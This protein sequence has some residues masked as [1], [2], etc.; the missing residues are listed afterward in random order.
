MFLI[1]RSAVDSKIY[2]CVKLHTLAVKQQA[3]IQAEQ[4]QD[5]GNVIGILGEMLIDN[6]LGNIRPAKLGTD[7]AA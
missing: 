1:M 6:N 3:Y 4:A 5:G 7:R 2:D